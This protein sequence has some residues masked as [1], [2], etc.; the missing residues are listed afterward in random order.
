[1]NIQSQTTG[2]FAAVPARNA[3][4]DN[5]G[6]G[7]GPAIRFSL[8]AIMVF[9][10]VLPGIGA[11]LGQLLF[12]D[13]ARGSLLMRDGKVVGS[14][15]IAQPFAD[16]KYFHPRPSA[17]GAGYDPTAMSGSNWGPS[18][19][20]LRERIAASSAEVAKLENVAASA[21]PSD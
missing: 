16:A 15:L 2:E 20:A 5:R 11:G 7:F 1:M 8:L 4:L 6:G 17:A 14:A 9:G 3:N 12:P 18:N 13:Q 21:I 10:L 19:P